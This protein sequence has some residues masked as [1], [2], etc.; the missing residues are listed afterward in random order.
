LAGWVA[1]Q[2]QS[3]LIAN[4]SQDARWLRRPD[5]EAATQGSKSALS[6]PLIARE[7]MVGVMTLVHLQPDSFTAED[8]SLLQ[9]IADQAAISVL[10]ARLFDKTRRRAEVMRALAETAAAISGSLD[11]DV[12][13]QRIL[14][15]ISQALQVEVVSWPCWRGANPCASRHDQRNR[16]IDPEHGWTWAKVSR[17]GQREGQAIIV[18]DTRPTLDQ[19]PLRPLT[20]FQTRLSPPRSTCGER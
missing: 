19:Q 1:R 8:L 20:G 6:V 11:L 9:A 14:E 7:Q 16:A 4:T 17:A 5:D 12:V 13:L 18:P 15:Q 3:A 2:Q 10:N